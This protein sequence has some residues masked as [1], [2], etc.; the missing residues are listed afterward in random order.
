LSISIERRREQASMGIV[1]L[2][3]RAVVGTFA[4][5]GAVTKSFPDLAKIGVNPVDVSIVSKGDT[6]DAF[7]VPRRGRWTLGI[8]GRRANWRL[9]PMLFEKPEIGR[10]VG[11]GPLAH[12]LVN[13]ASTSP[14]GA[15]V[16]QGIPQ[17]DALTFAELLAR[18]NALI[19]VGVVDRTMAERVRSVLERVGSAKVAYYSGRP[20]G[21]AFH[22][23]GPGL[24]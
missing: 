19:L 3:S 20:Y 2:A 23:T 7:Q 17:Q 22:G 16:M 6:V 1:R 21:T 14:V 4:N 5:S 10:L 9:E 13:S 11:A 8:L 12:V 18:G 24:R 15:L